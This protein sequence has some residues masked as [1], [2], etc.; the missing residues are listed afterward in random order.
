MPHETDALVEYDIQDVDS[1]G[2]DKLY[3]ITWKDTGSSVLVR[4]ADSIFHGKGLFCAQ[5][6]IPAGQRLDHYHGVICTRQEADR[7]HTSN[8]DSYSLFS[9]D[10]VVPYPHLPG[11]FC[12]DSVVL[13]DSDEGPLVYLKTANAKFEETPEALIVRTISDIQQDEEI[14]ISYGEVR[15]VGRILQVQFVTIES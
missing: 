12:N 8:M 1:E 3:R 7:L 10:V 15:E 5:D 6:C 2:I 14:I 9:S 4:T 13:P 11:R